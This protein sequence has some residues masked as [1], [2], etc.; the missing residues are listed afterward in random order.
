VRSGN[1]ASLFPEAERAMSREVEDEANSYFQRIYNHPPHP[2][3]SIDEVLELLKKFQTSGGQ[4]ETDVFF[5][6]IK[7]GGVPL[8]QSYGSYP[9]VLGIRD[10]LVRIR[11]R[12][13]NLWSVPLTNG[14][15]CVSGMPQN[16]RIL[17][18]RI[19]NTG[20]KSYI[21]HKTEEIM[22]FLTI[23]A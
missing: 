7:A 21:N 12:I 17:R 9:A 11:M 4:R 16:I 5:C 15:G 8:V 18:I 3:L 1:I 20:K 22:V 14:S 6:M 2:T 19:R 23:F 13:R 10:I